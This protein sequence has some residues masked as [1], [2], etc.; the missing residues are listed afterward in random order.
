MLSAGDSIRLVPTSR[1]GRNRI[2]EAGTD[3]FEVVSVVGQIACRPGKGHA[4]LVENDKDIRW[5]NLRDDPDF[6]IQKV[7]E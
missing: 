1:H 7:G 2:R 5:V 3:L 6:E 4:A